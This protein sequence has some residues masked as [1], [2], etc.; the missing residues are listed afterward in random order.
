[1]TTGYLFRSDMSNEPFNTSAMVAMLSSKPVEHL[2]SQNAIH[3]P[4]TAMQHK[5]ALPLWRPR[6]GRNE[7]Y[8]KWHD[9]LI[10][11]EYEFGIDVD[12]P[13]PTLSELVELIPHYSTQGLL[14]DDNREAYALYQA[15]RDEWIYQNEFQFDVIRASLI[16]EGDNSCG[17][18]PSADT[19]SE[20]CTVRATPSPGWKVRG[21]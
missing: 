5:P 17:S 1:M 6:D 10:N 19:I 9:A 21:L 8:L 12:T 20:W 14:D 16:L 13:C 4:H 3:I 15:S 11:L 18:P 7:T 2:K